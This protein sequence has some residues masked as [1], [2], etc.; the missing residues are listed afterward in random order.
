M[1]K[2]LMK[3]FQIKMLRDLSLTLT[4]GL[5]IFA[6][7]HASDFVSAVPPEM[8]KSDIWV[9]VEEAD[10]NV[11]RQ[12]SDDSYSAKI[13]YLVQEK[14]PADDGYF[15]SFPITV[16]KDGEYE[17]WLASSSWGV[18]WASPVQFFLDDEEI[19]PETAERP[20]NAW[21]ISKSLSWNRFGVLPMKA[22]EHQFR[23]V[24]NHGRPLDGKYVICV[25]GIALVRQGD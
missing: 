12:S 19:T 25:D 11:P 23:M 7:G 8:P 22:G 1:T 3:N 10:G 6:E 4:V 16:A 20:A 24:V 17:V 9:S 2:L 21:G 15:V 5:L 18:N 14:A 13:A